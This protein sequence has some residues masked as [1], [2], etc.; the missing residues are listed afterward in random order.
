MASPRTLVRGE[1]GLACYAAFLVV[2]GGLTYHA[3]RS[4]EA[5]E[6]FKKKYE[7]AYL[8]CTKGIEPGSDQLGPKP[9]L[10]P[11]LMQGGGHDVDHYI[12]EAKRLLEPFREVLEVL[13]KAADP[14]GET[15]TVFSN[16]KG[17]EVSAMVGSGSRCKHG[18]GVYMV[19]QML[20]QAKSNST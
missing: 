7:A 15:V 19:Q 5:V 13:A 4:L 11:H 2:A 16:T 18:G 9:M 3:V 6:V 10:N 17:E 1:A 14:T 12:A 8:E 20:Q